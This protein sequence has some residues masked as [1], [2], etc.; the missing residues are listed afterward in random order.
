MR[1]KLRRFVPL[2]FPV[3]L[4]ACGGKQ[5][6]LSNTLKAMEATSAAVLTYSDVEERRILDTATSGE[7]GEMNLAAF[8]AK[9][10]RFKHLMGMTA[11]VLGTAAADDTGKAFAEGMAVAA[12][13]FAEAKSL[14]GGAP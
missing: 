12:Q 6:I 4:L 13:L 7:D 3:L 2:L 11:A 1:H 14:M 9:V 10:D 8:R 5:A